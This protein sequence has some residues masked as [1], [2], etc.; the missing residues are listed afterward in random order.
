MT[1]REKQLE[2]NLYAIFAMYE[3][4]MY[5]EGEENYPQMDLEDCIDYAIGQV[6]DMMDDGMGTTYYRDGICKD[7]KFLGNDY[8]NKE[9]SRIAADCG[10]LK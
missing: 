2:N 5:D 4:G 10:V 6:Y 9:I 7:L 3:N 8:I 1:K